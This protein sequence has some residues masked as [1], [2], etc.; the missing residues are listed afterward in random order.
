MRTA[1]RAEYALRI[2]A[3]LLPWMKSGF[4]LAIL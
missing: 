3:L 2:A 4:S 1:A